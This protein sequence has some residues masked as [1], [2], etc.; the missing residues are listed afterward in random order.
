MAIQSKFSFVKCRKIR[1][2]F[3][4]RNYVVSCITRQK[5]IQCMHRTGIEHNDSL[6]HK[7]VGSWDIADVITTGYGQDDGVRVT[8]GSRLHFIH[9]FHCITR[10]KV[11]QC[12]HCT[13]IE[14]N[15]SLQHKTV[16]SWHIADVIT[17]GYGQDDGVRVTVGSR[18][19]FST[20]L[21]PLERVPG[22]LER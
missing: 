19:H 21:R 18:L 16:G 9:S 11:I 6:Q 10:Q 15:D 2:V 3:L 8:V 17:T 4:L 12:M 22:P 1:V 13:G 14:H 7:T 20:V 5:A